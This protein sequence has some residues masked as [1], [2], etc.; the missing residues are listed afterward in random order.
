MGYKL[1]PLDLSEYKSA[2]DITVDLI[3]ILEEQGFDEEK[4]DWGAKQYFE[5]YGEIYEFVTQDSGKCD[6]PGCNYTEVL[7]VKCVQTKNELVILDSIHTRQFLNN[8][9][10]CLY[11][12]EQCTY[13]IID[14]EKK[15]WRTSFDHE[16]LYRDEPKLTT[17]KAIK[18]KLK[19]N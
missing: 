15:K 19:I 8:L 2:L 12:T 9:M 7:Y 14:I 18:D 6:E 11:A 4:A 17:L 13:L 10:D 1:L 5:F 16:W 3:D